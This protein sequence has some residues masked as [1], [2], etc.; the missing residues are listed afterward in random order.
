MRIAVLLCAAAAS[1]VLAACGSDTQ[2][3][4]VA[5]SN[6][7]G[8]LIIDPPL[9]LASLNATDLA[10]N[11]NASATGAQLLQLTGAPLCGVDF[12]YIQYWTIDGTGQPATASGALMVPTGAAP[13]CSGTL[14]VV[15]YAHGTQTDK[16]FN[17]ADITNTSNTE[18]QLIA[19]TFAAQG[20]IVIAPNYAGYD[21]SSLHYHPFANAA[22]QSHEMLDAMNAALSGLAKSFTPETSS[23][24]KVFV[25]GYDEGGYVAMATQRALQAAK[26]PA[27]AAA[28]MSGPYALEAD[29]DAVFYGNVNLGAPVFASLFV[30]SYQ[31]AYGNVYMAPTD[32]F[33][34]QFAGAVSLLPN[35]TSIAQ[36]FE[37]G[38]LPQTQLFSSTPPAPALASI[39]P[40]TPPA[41]T[42]QQYAIFSLGFG[43]DNLVT[44]DFRLA[45]LEDAMAHP[46]ELVPAPTPP[47][48]PA[49]DPQ[50]GLRKDLKL[51]DL[52]NWSPQSPTLLCGGDQDPTVFFDVNTVG[53]QSYWLAQGVPAALV[54]VLDVNGAPAGPFA[55]LQ[56]AFQTTEAQIVATQGLQAAVQSYHTE[57]A[58]FCTVAARGFFSQFL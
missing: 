40:P 16:S 25:T 58:P 44:N 4:P 34:P 43:P 10:A 38:L 46:D 31:N 5:T 20:F 28:P 45:Y 51:N 24:G 18:G 55:Q 49:A 50:F 42:P 8:T 7:A 12:Y 9:R 33:E 22:Q 36:L 21:T 1:V 35:A 14:P 41:V 32:I 37:L 54:T 19:A 17:I 48:A 26:T 29:G 15:L 57:V 23:S 11:F 2:P 56:V 6:A 30:S 53:I 47:F 52:R 3:A 39:T 13:R 27:V